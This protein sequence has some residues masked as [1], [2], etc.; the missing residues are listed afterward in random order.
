[1][2]ECSLTSRPLQA[3]SVTISMSP[4]IVSPHLPAWAQQ[5]AGLV[6][7]SALIEFID[8]G[9]KLHLFELAGSVAL[10]NWPVTPAGAKL[11]L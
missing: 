6:P 4:L 10:W 7:L 3:A 2:T 9:M 11:L 5:L 8:I 1:M